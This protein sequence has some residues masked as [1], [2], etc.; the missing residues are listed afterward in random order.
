MLLSRTGSKVN[1]LLREQPGVEKSESVS[2]S[3][4]AGSEGR[5]S[6]GLFS[7]YK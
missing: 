4:T 3:S 7:I 6:H 2:G 5:R 1:E